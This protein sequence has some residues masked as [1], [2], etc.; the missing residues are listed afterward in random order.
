VPNLIALTGPVILVGALAG[1]IVSGIAGFGGGPVILAVW[2]LVLP[3]QT[4]APLLTVA[5]LCVM[6]FNINL[7]RHA[8]S[9]QRLWPFFL[10]G[11]IG[12]P[13]G[14]ALLQ[15]VS[16]QA[17][18]RI[19]GGFL[20]AYAIMRLSILRTL[21]IYVRGWLPDTAAS[22]GVIAGLAGTPGPP[23]SLWCGLRGWGKD[24]QRAVV[25]PYNFLC[26]IA[27]IAAYAQSGLITG[28]IGWLSLWAIPGAVIGNQL[29]L[30]IYKRMSDTQFQTLLIWLLL[31]MGVLLLL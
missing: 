4:A 22:A 19:V 20:V 8:L 14:A 25:A 10:G 23:I 30:P 17:F 3:P 28:Q 12:V 6:A 15:V 1:G 11:L 27:A 26:T 13:F 21:Q 24:E 18:R 16:P 31:A 29:G 7:V 9:W 5:F 2:L